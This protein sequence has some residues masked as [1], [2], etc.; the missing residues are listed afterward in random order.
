MSTEAGAG[1]S[2]GFYVLAREL[3]VV[4]DRLRSLEAV[5][6]QRGLDVSAA[7]DAYAPAP[8]EQALRDA[9]CRRLVEALTRELAGRPD[10]IGG[11][12]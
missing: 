1:V 10:G 8:Q 12:K 6:A 5:L 4:A 3:W 7:V 9:E 2:A 11:A